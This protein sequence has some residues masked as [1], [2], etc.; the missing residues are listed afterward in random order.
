MDAVGRH[1]EAVICNIWEAAA[2]LSAPCNRE[3][4]FFARLFQ[5]INQIWRFA[6]GTNRQRHVSR[7]AEQTQLIYEYA[8]KIDVVA[9]CRH[10]GGIVHQ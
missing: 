10:R 5:R 9:H 6:A 1:N 3:H 2:V 8:R 7:L 4:F